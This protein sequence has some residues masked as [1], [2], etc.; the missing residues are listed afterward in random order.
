MLFRSFLTNAFL[1]T[2]RRYFGPTFSSSRDLLGLLAY[3][4]A[5]VGATLFVSKAGEMEKRPISA[6]W[7]RRDPELEAALS[8]QLQ[9]F[10]QVLLK[11]LRQ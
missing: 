7:G 2:L 3:F 6:M 10:N 4:V 11:V 1:Y 5:L 8:S 9:S